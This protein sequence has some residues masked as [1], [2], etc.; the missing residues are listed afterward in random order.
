MISMSEKEKMD[1]KELEDVSGGMPENYDGTRYC[2]NCAAKY[3]VPWDLFS[4]RNDL[5]LCE[6]CAGSSALKRGFRHFAH[7]VFKH[8]Y[9]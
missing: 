2:K 5:G 1:V 6:T 9:K 7:K 4:S 8:E 3:Y